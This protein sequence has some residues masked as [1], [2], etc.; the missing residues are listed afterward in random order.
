MDSQTGKEANLQ[1]ASLEA[2]AAAYLGRFSK[3]LHKCQQELVTRIER[4]TAAFYSLPDLPK[5]KRRDRNALLLDF[6]QFER[7]LKVL[8]RRLS[9]ETAADRHRWWLL[10]VKGQ[11]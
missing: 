3:D 7:L 10:R 1:S 9:R 4:L 6:T 2:E 8:K 5:M 11:S